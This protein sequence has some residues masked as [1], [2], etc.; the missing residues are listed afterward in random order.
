MIAMVMAMVMEMLLMKMRVVVMAMGIT[1]TYVRTYTGVIVM[2]AITM[3]VWW[4]WGR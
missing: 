4:R 1:T 2:T 3:K